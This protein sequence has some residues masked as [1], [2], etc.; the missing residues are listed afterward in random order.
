MNKAKRLIAKTIYVVLIVTMSMMTA[1]A[2]ATVYTEETFQ[3]TVNDHS[4]TIVGYFG[5]SDVV[6]IPSSIA[7]TPVNTIATGAF[8]GTKAKKV[9]LPDTIMSIE[10]GAFPT[11]GSVT[12]VN[13]DGTNY[14]EGKSN[15]G[16]DKTKDDANP[17]KKDTKKED[18]KNKDI[19]KDEIGTTTDTDITSS[20]TVQSVK[21]KKL[22]SYKKAFT[23]KW[24]ANSKVTGYQIKYSLK[25]NMANAKTI[26]IKNSKTASKK[27]TKL[28]SKKKYYVKIRAYKT[29]DNKK[30]YS[31][32]SKAKKITTK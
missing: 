31:S 26:T 2:D 3:Y 16:D 14:I 12:V 9:I 28:K 8:V 23:V 17:S 25:S 18:I 29:I 22:T 30:H 7:G 10:D 13:A 1:F 20:V 11:D 5:K 27:I 15:T 24:K 4:V 21:I 32:W 6:E 19:V